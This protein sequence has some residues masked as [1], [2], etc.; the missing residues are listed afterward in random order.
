MSSSPHEVRGLFLRAFVQELIKNYPL[1]P[2]AY[3][4]SRDTNTQEMVVPEKRKDILPIPNKPATPPKEF[5]IALQ[6]SEPEKYDPAAYESTGP[7]MIVAIREIDQGPA[8]RQLQISQT[9]GAAPLTQK[10]TNSIDQW[11]SD[12]TIETI[13]CIGPG[14]ALTLKNNKGFMK[15]NTTYTQEEIKKQ[16]EQWVREAR[17]TLTQGIAKAETMNWTLLGILSEFG[18]NR[19]ILQKKQ[20]R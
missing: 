20:K 15:T 8:P 9:Q 1:S 4:P 16:V 7:K 10:P 18:G 3:I 2:E 12:P 6:K 17:G 11:I 5:N 13:E 14:Q 19:F